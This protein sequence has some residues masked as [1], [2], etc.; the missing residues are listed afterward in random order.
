MKNIGLRAKVAL[1]VS[2]LVVA[3]ITINAAITL[4]TER[5][6]RERQLLEQGMLFASL[7]VT[8]VAR[9][10]G[11]LPMGMYGK[12]AGML[13]TRMERF[14]NYYPDLTRLMLLA[15]DGRVLFD[16]GAGQAGRPVFHTDDKELI[17]RLKLAVM[18]VKSITGEDGGKYMD[19]VTPVTSGGPQFI[20]ARYIISYRSMDNRLADIRS[21]FMLLA[22]FFIV[23]GILAAGLFSARLTSPILGLKDVAGEIARG[24]LEQVVDVSGT[25]EIAEL[26][27]SFNTM[28]LSLKEHRRSL[29]LANR[30]LISANEELRHLQDELIRSERMA[31]VGQLAAGLSHEIDNPIGIILG[32]A[33]L[34]AADMPEDDPRREDLQTI[35]DE[36]RRCKRIVRGLLDFSRPPVLG[37]V[38]TD[39]NEVVRATVGA[40]ESQRLFKGVTVRTELADGTPALTADPD[41]LRQV[42]MNLLINAAQA[43]DGEGSIDVATGYDPETGVVGITFAD[44]GPGIKDA[45]M[46]NVFEPF[47]TT[48]RPGEGTGLGLAICKRLLEEQGGTITATNRADGGAVFSVSLPVG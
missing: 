20:K 42:F 35:I 21:E 27:K 33:E 5:H 24:N 18:D 29:E 39:V 26:G 47:F 46:E 34:L 41:R 28:A 30:N 13:S 22:G 11:S 19:I 23:A 12:D 4:R 25:D 16:S 9:T 2:V 37:V 44:T 1:F 31:A 17:K 48:K 3:I 10:F 36:S 43:M 38:P 6:E 45:D 40:A 8:D 7:T 32:F 14:F 15:E